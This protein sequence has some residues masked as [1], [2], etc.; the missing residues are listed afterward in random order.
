[1]P[2]KW[3]QYFTLEIQ[4]AGSS[5]KTSDGKI[6][7]RGLYKFFNTYGVPLEDILFVLEKKGIIP[8]W[9]DFYD[10]CIRHG[11]NRRTVMSKLEVAVGEI[12]GPRFKERVIDTLKQVR[13]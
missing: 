12:F 10:D 13:P 11:M 4:H 6:V 1:L 8:D 2:I 7:V 9:I 3:P 5:G